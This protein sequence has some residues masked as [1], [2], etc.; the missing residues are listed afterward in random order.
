MVELWRAAGN[1]NLWRKTQIVIYG[2]NSGV[3]TFL[4]IAI[5]QPAI[6]SRR[7]NDEK[8]ERRRRV[9]LKHLLR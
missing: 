3:R 6:S 9:L 5:S 2:T 7:Q 8:Y 4:L 1:R